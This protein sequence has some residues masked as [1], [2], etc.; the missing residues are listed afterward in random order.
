[1]TE[2]DTFDALKRTPFLTVRKELTDL[3]LVE[4]ITIQVRARVLHKHGWTEAEWMLKSNNLTAYEVF[5]ARGYWK[6]MEDEKER[7][8]QEFLN[9]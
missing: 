1:M 2:E 5:V 9:R 8:I 3:H 7:R 6:R 4:L